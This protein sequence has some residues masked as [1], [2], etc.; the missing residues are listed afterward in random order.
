[1][2]TGAGPLLA[3]ALTLLPRAAWAHAPIPG[4]GAFWNGVVH[5][6]FIPIHLLALVG[7]GIALGQNA[8]RASRL[9]LPL[10]SVLLAGG[11][12]LATPAG[13]PP[14]ALLAIA[15]A[16]GLFAALGQGTVML[17]AA[18][19]G[20]AGATVGLDSAPLEATSGEALL[21]SAGTF[22]GCLLVV[23]LV[24]GLAAAASAP[25][26]SIAIR[27]A[28]SWIAAAALI[29]LALALFDPAALS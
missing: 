10:L 23:V 15:L 20:A 24:G 4:V 3:I 8:P 6:L 22:A 1:M 21:A 11:I 25:W 13:S 28:G 16:G 19:A 2:I 5:P 27:A 14:A 26:Q 29:A 18:L 9:A 17:V 7:V 12:A